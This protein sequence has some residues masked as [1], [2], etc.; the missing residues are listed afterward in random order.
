MRVVFIFLSNHLFRFFLLPSCEYCRTCTLFSQP[1]PHTLSHR[2]FSC[3]SP[4]C[5]AGAYR[6]RCWWM[7]SSHAWSW[8]SP[9][10][11]PTR[12]TPAWPTNLVQPE[13]RSRSEKRDM[14][15]KKTKLLKYGWLNVEKCRF[16]PHL[17]HHMKSPSTPN[18]HSLGNQ[19][20]C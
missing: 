4:A 5:A 19:P 15:T 2:F 3:S 17:Q 9:S 13:E 18:R 10:E 14:M 11:P 8:K 20:T 12:A 7:R 1:P 6:L 16:L